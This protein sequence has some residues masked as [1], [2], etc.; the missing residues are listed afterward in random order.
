MFETLP[1][2][3]LK[4]SARTLSVSE[5]ST[6]SMLT[7]AVALVVPPPSITYWKVSV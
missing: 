4:A 3:T 6:T 7:V 5:R 1:A 2:G